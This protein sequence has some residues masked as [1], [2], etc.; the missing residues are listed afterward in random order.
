MAREDMAKMQPILKEV[1]LFNISCKAF[2]KTNCK[3][4]QK[5]MDFSCLSD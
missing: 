1:T 2:G 3:F 4:G 5:G